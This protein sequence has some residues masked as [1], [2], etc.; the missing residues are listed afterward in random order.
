MKDKEITIGQLLL[1]S[2][3]TDQIAS[4]LEVVASA[5]YLKSLMDDFMRA[6]PD[7][8]ATVDEILKGLRTKADE[9]TK[10]QPVSYKRTMEYWNSLWRHWH[11]ILADVGNEEGKYAVQDH[12]WEEPYFNG[13]Y[14]ASD[15]EPIARD[16][17][18]LIDDV[19]VSVGDPDLFFDLLEDIETSIAS[20]PEWMGAEYGEPCELEKYTTSC[21]LKWLW[22]DL[23]HEPRSGISLLEKVYEIEISYKLVCIN[24]MAFVDFFVNL[25]ADSCREIYGY[26]RDDETHEIDL[27][28]VYSPWHQINH[29]YES[30]FDSSKH[31]ETCRNHLDHNWQYGRPLIDDAIN[32]KEFQEAEQWLVKT[33]S[34]FLERKRKA[35]WYPESSLL[36][37]QMDY[38]MGDGQEEI[39]ALLLV[40]S[41]VSLKLGNSQ[42]GTA[43][44]FQ[45]TIFRLPEDCEAVIKDYKRV[46]GPKT[47]KTIDPIF[48]QWKNEMANCSFS[49]YMDAPKV[50]DSWVHWL[51]EASLDPKKKKKWFLSKLND[52]L[53]ELKKDKKIFKKQW[54][55]LARLTSDLPN[56]KRL[57]QKYPVFYKT[58][59]PE[60]DSADDLLGNF[61]CRCL[62]KMNA[63]PGLL[64]AMEVWK[65]V[66]HLIVP[67]PA[68]A[69]KS[70]Y[71]D[72]AAWCKALHE[73]N[74][75][76]YSALLSR[77]RKKHN[78]RRNLWRDMKAIGLL[79]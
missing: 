30:R 75:N 14:L 40:W 74:Q 16:M 61:R 15:L 11:E 56:S 29:V 19:Y 38:Y 64:K 79:V 55:Q 48:G 62:K 46:I 57:V 76:T 22:S 68:N 18:G 25:P 45:G 41:E 59:L 17:L 13:S 66:L 27:N 10:S 51:I 70:D 47:R 72:H 26:L 9:K 58:V 77:W 73:L 32:R 52:W 2:L 6:D 37:D 54:H 49:R 50:S 12:H 69:Y 8:A 24:Q 1:E 23:Q 65:E 44:Q 20:Y 60:E 3:T 67:D 39:A 71:S 53:N 34:S 31:L 33:F 7:M 35:K 63:G 43:A 28:N 78:R 4:M 5:G 36:M 21:V 42:R